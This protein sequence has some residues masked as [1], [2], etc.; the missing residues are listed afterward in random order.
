M[1]NR[2]FCKKIIKAMILA[3]PGLLGLPLAFFVFAIAHSGIVT[4]S[5]DFSPAEWKN[6]RST[7]L[8][9]TSTRAGMIGSLEERIEEL[10]RQEVLLLLGQGEANLHAD[11]CDKYSLGAGTTLLNLTTMWLEV[12]YGSNLKVMT[13]RTND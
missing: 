2:Q 10:S 7:S 3:A 13:F 8:L 4:R 9:F 11:T 1:A 12:C 5:R 6:A